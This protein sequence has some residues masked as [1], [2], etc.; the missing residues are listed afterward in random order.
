[1]DGIEDDGDGD[2]AM[3]ETERIREVEGY[4]D[5]DGEITVDG[6]RAFLGARPREAVDEALYLHLACAHAGITAAVVDFLMAAFPDA[7]RAPAAW[8]TRLAP[9]EESLSQL[10]G[11]V[12]SPLPLHL[13]CA[14][15]R[16]P[17]AVIETLLA[18]HPA[19]AA[20]VCKGRW[21]EEFSPLTELVRGYDEVPQLSIA[22]K[23]LPLHYYLSRESD[24]ELV[25]V[26]T[27][28]EAHPAALAEDVADYSPLEVLLLNRNVGDFFDTVQFLLKRTAERGGFRT[29]PLHVACINSHVSLRIVKLLVARSPESVN[30]E[31]SL[32]WV[33][34]G[35][36]IHLLLTKMCS[37]GD[38]GP[39]ML[40]VLE[41]LI[42]T[43]PGSLQRQVSGHF[44]IHD[45]VEYWREPEFVKAILRRD[46]ASASRVTAETALTRRSLPLHLAAAKSANLHVLQ[47]LFDA[48]PEGIWTIDGQ[49]RTPLELATKTESLDHVINTV[50]LE[51]KLAYAG[52][53]KN[54]TAMAT[55]DEN[56]QL[57]LH[58]ALRDGASLGVIKLLTQANPTAFEHRDAFGDYPLHHA[59][60]GKINVSHTYTSSIETIRLLVDGN[61]AALKHPGF[62]GDYPLHHACRARNYA[63]VKFLLGCQAAPASELNKEC[64]LPIQLLCQSGTNDQRPEVVET[65]WLL[66]RAYPE[67][68]M[69]CASE[70]RTNKEGDCCLSYSRFGKRES[71]RARKK[72]KLTKHA[73]AKILLD[74]RG[75]M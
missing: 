24:I 47:L 63:V 40:D 41:Y 68:L 69:H 74:L 45:A 43:S 61:P 39:E 72:P 15:P 32:D 27:L 75:V 6:L 58:H 9:E 49:G 4:F 20:T 55:P 14:N 29:P 7:A 35:L 51:S 19:A 53:A 34:T 11:G 71:Q 18:T 10:T 28:V 44:P 5:C 16:C 30:E 23:G 73:Y 52:L 65:I 25:M 59:C 26:K 37:D 57:P 60:R 50:F 46:P 13:A 12:V 33:P 22:N 38:R 70:Q 67:I 3:F 8:G 1:M 64:K 36:P 48:H 42:E 54:P 62:F 31:A 56:G 66:L 2:S 17:A 21:D